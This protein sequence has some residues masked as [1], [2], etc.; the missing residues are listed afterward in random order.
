MRLRGKFRVITFLDNFNPAARKTYG[1][2]LGFDPP[3]SLSGPAGLWW[4]TGE[5]HPIRGIDLVWHCRVYLGSLVQDVQLRLAVA[6]L[7]SG[8]LLRGPRRVR[9]IVRDSESACML[10]LTAEPKPPLA[11][12]R[13]AWY[14]GKVFCVASGPDIQQTTLYSLHEDPN[15]ED[16]WHLY[17]LSRCGVPSEPGLREAQWRYPGFDLRRLALGVAQ[18]QVQPGDIPQE[19]LASFLL[20]REKLIF[21]CLALMDPDLPDDPEPEDG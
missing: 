7:D 2:L 6:G 13:P 10:Q 12:P 15:P 17:L 1:S 21:Q 14:H 19:H 18:V 8:V 11:P 4:R 9:L 3:W 20:F 5:A 16:L